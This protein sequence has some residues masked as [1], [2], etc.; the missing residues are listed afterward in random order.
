MEARYHPGLVA[1]SVIV[2]MLASYVALDLAA[3]VN[4]VRRSAGPRWEQITWGLGGATAMGIGIWSMHF[5]AMLA[6]QLPSPIRYGLALLIASMLPAIGASAL[7]LFIASRPQVSQRAVFAGG[8]CMG[9]GIAAMHYTGM[10]AI[11]SPA[12]V[13]YHSGL[14]WLSVAIAIVA[15]WAAL[16]LA[17]VLRGHEG[18]WM[19]RRA[20]A[21]VVMGFAIAGMHY[22]GMAAARFPHPVPGAEPVIAGGVLATTGLAIA[23]TLGALLHPG[24]RS[25]GRGHEPARAPPRR[26]TEGA[27]RGSAAAR[28]RC[29]TRP[30]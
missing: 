10:A 11:V 22:T 15:S 5:I 4:A 7:A 29:P 13:H 28:G 24:P 27:A 17:F 21:A 8:L 30:H 23:V 19:P 12:G 26:G 20:L 16:T 6:L 18:L 9:I 2:A 14:W 3:R 25:G 1:V